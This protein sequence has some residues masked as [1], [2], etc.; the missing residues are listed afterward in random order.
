MWIPTNEE[1]IVKVVMSGSLEE[2]AIF[3]AKKE[4]PS[5]NQEIAKDIAAMAND[6]G[7][8]IYGIDEDEH[9]RP[10]IL[11][12]IP[13]KN[14]AE[15]ITSIVRTGITEPP[16]IKVSTIPTTANS[17]EGYLIVV[18]PAS[19]RAP[20]MVVLRGH[21]RY[22]GR[23]ATGNIPLVEAEI[24]RLYERRQRWEVD[25]EALIAQ[26]IEN[27]PMSPQPGFAYL[28]LIAQPVILS[29]DILDRVVQE[30]QTIHGVLHDLVNFVARADLYPQDYAPDFNPP[31]RWIRRVEGFI[32][33]MD[34]AYRLE[35]KMSPE[36]ALTIQIDFNG[37]GHLFCGR[38]AQ[39]MQEQFLFFPAL[40]AGITIRFVA[41]LGELYDRANY[42]GSVDIGVSVT[43]MKG[44]VPYR[45]T[46]G[47]SLYDRD[48]YTYTDRV[49]AIAFK[50][51]PYQIAKILL[52]PLFDALS[53]GLINP[54]PETGSS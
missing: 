7:V 28:Y 19:P 25:R 36:D 32:G 39:Q 42:I 26:E 51:D 49:S 40:V 34:Y 46:K 15:R 1:E 44:C 23:T 6:G 29:S 2:S 16:V 43:G 22:Y 37:T 5:K 17:S 30:G 47:A 45:A 38:A 31:R 4:L 50:N 53:Q 3:D 48:E 12:P 24:A 9:G 33:R 27:A 8:I 14:Q 54:F 20:H 10:T 21:N 18:V 52:M 35:D 13:L 41:L 11:N